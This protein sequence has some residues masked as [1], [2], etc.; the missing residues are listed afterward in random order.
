M[1]GTDEYKD[2]INTL[3]VSSDELLKDC[4]DFLNY[5]IVGNN[6]ETNEEVIPYLVTPLF[7]RLIKWIDGKVNKDDKGDY[8]YQGYDVPKYVMI[9]SEEN[10][11]STFMSYMN[12]IF[13]T[14]IQFPYYA[15]NLH[16]EL[17][18]ED[19]ENFRIEY[20]YNDELLLSIPYSEF[21]EKINENLKKSE[22]I[23]EFCKFVDEEAEEEDNLFYL[24]GTIVSSV[25][26][27][28][29]MVGII[30]IIKKRE[31]VS[32]SRDGSKLEPIKNSSSRDSNE[33]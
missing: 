12:M 7:K 27:V 9:S 24:V 21:K 1:D 33:I 22:E 20:Y 11:L 32:E 10:T 14:K 8:E 13:G 19:Y 4:Y 25:I 30:C 17:Y 23:D 6:T 28:G 15:T 2:I 26:A 16:I 31:K 3:G 29:L 5:N 18:L